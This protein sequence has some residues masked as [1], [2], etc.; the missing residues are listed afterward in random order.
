MG[1]ATF[2]ALAEKLIV[3][4]LSGETPTVVIESLGSP[5]TS[6]MAGTLTEIAVRLTAAKPQGPCMILYGAALA[7]VGGDK[8]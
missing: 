1:K 3:E 7:G 8:A 6:V 2:A 4:G 5:A